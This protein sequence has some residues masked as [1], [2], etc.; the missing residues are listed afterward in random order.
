MTRQV[1]IVEVERKTPE[2]LLPDAESTAE[3]V[4]NQ[5]MEFCAQKMRLEDRQA[6]LKHLQQHDATSCKYCCYGIAR[7]VGD[8]L[9]TLDQNVKAVYT[10]D[11]DATPEDICFARE[12][13]MTLIHLIV[14]VERKTS[15]LQSLVEGLDRALAGC[16]ARRL[17]VDR[18]KYL[19]DVQ[20]VDDADVEKRVGYGA[21]FS[22][23][24]HRPIKVWER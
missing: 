1:R 6:V 14:W 9:G 8:S 17:G 4:I 11:Y 2:L 3:T 23:L 19:L 24:Y 12:E 20:I 16:F 5:A 10:V 15:A 7:G 21:M 18:L 13:Q 22:S